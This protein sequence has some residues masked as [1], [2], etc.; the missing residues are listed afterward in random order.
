M[1]V[2][3]SLDA[4][5]GDDVVVCRQREIVG[6]HI[7]ARE[8]VLSKAQGM[9]RD[10]TYCIRLYGAKDLA[11]LVARAG[12]DALEVHPHGARQHLGVDVGCMN[13]R[14]AVTARRP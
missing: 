1:A 2:D 7:R 9:V 11:A 12:F 6:D 14:L 10:C 3:R 13:H 8:M 4:G 5:I